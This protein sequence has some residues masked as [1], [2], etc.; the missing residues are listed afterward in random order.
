MV[1]LCE[2]SDL[3]KTHQLARVSKAHSAVMLFK[4]KATTGNNV[5]YFII[6][7]TKV[8]VKTEMLSADE[9]KLWLFHLSVKNTS[10]SVEAAVAEVCR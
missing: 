2:T 10:I 5:E 1:D 3:N 9:Q 8:A 7:C 4:C 6:G